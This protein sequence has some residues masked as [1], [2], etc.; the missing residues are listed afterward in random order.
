[1]DELESITEGRPVTRRLVMAGWAGLGAA[2]LVGARLAGAQESTP[3]AS[4]TEDA[5]DPAADFETTRLL[6]Y[7]LFLESMSGSLGVADLTSIDLAI[8]DGLKAVVDHRLAEGEISADSAEERKAAIDAATVP[9]A[10][11][12]MRPGSHDGWRG[13]GNSG[14]ERGSNRPDR[15]PA[16]DEPATDDPAAESTPTT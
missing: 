1:M 6:Y 14:G 13:R 2:A 15:T 11:G 4:D 3:G 8:R 12:M 5:T 16:G 9:I 7:S 10:V